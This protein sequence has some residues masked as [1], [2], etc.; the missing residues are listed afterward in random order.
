MCVQCILQCNY[1]HSAENLD[2]LHLLH[3]YDLTFQNILHSLI[4]SLILLSCFTVLCCW[5]ICSFSECRAEDT[6]TQTTEV[7]A[8]E[9]ESLTLD[10]NYRTSD[11]SPY[12]YW[13]IQY[14]NG[15]PQYMLRWDLYSAGETAPGF[16]RFDAHLNKTSSS[17]P[18]TIQK[19]QLSDSAVY[20][21]ALRPT[22]V[23]KH[24][25]PLQKHWAQRGTNRNMD[26]AGFIL[27]Q[28][29]KNCFNYINHLCIMT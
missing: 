29:R 3:W 12:L 1:G 22:V 19:V 2:N 11:R 10:C 25:P 14:P 23:M 8:F 7:E 24:S 5:Y 16:E 13:Y 4:H 15:F 27:R 17:V 26:Y 28:G 21:C 18:L 20:Y 9:G 6:V